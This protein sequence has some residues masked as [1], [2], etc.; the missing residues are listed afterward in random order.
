MGEQKMINYAHGRGKEPGP[1]TKRNNCAHTTEKKS[2]IVTKEDTKS[3]S[4]Y[5][6]SV[7]TMTIVKKY[8]VFSKKLQIDIHPIANCYIIY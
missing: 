1:V 3:L 7:R 6:S 5:L 4:F 8:E 2:W